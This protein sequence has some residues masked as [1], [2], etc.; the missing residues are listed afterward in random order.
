MAEIGLIDSRVSCLVIDVR[1]RV[2]EALHLLRMSE[3]RA[4]SQLRHIAQW[5]V[6][7]GLVWK[8]VKVHVNLKL[9]AIGDIE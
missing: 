5:I 3:E 6:V 9:R 1:C 4:K 7:T 8:A 2:L